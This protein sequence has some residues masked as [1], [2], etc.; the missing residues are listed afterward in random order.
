[1]ETPENGDNLPCVDLMTCLMLMVPSYH[2]LNKEDGLLG[3]ALD[4]VG[5]GARFFHEGDVIRVVARE[6]LMMVFERRDWC[7]RILTSVWPDYDPS[8]LL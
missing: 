4:E 7:F 5:Q 1:M 8:H 3:Q 2:S 6:Q